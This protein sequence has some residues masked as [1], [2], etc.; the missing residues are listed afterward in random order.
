MPADAGETVKFASNFIKDFAPP[1]SIGDDIE[2]AQDPE[3]ANDIFV[4]QINENWKD[5]IKKEIK[6]GDTIKVAYIDV[7]TNTVVLD[8]YDT[9]DEQIEIVQQLFP[10]LLQFWNQRLLPNSKAQSFLHR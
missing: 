9:S 5:V 3:H 2:I 4:Y 7:L 8:E 6:K 1:V 10:M